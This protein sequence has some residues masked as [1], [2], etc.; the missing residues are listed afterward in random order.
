LN[1]IA[2]TDLGKSTTSID[3]L[4]GSATVVELEGTDAKTG[5]PARMIAAM[6]PRKDRTWFYKMM[7][8]PATVTAQKAAFEKFVQT[9]RYPND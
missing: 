4:G 9:V 3:V 8:D 5:N 1:P 6:V 2:Q 7:G